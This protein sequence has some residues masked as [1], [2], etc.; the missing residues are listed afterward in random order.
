MSGG[1]AFDQV[2]PILRIYDE[3]KAREFYGGFL[4]CKVD[5]EARFDE[6]APIYMQVSRGA[7]V[8][9]LSEHV[10][11]GTPG[12]V[13]LVRTAGLDALHSELNGKEYKYMRPGIEGRPWGTRELVVIDPFG[14]RI[15]FS[16][17][18]PRA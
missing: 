2:V 3:A 4:G 12:S 5:W 11:D 9:H 7:M 18:K 14:N 6:K 13:V 1:P 16:E 15:T 17:E 10:G 8:L